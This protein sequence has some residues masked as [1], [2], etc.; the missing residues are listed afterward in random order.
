MKANK[1]VKALIC[2]VA[3]VVSVPLCAKP[4]AKSMQSQQA[5]EMQLSQLLSGLKTMQAN[6][7]Q[8]SYDIHG[9]ILQK[10]TGT[11]ALQR[12]GKFRW[13]IKTPHKQMYIADGTYLWTYDAALAQ[14][15]KQRLNPAKNNNPASLLSGSVASLQ[16]RFYVTETGNTKTGQWFQLKPKAKN[17][18]FRYIELHFQNNQLNEMKLSDNLGQLST[19][20]FSN[21]QI[22]TNLD[23]KL[24]QFAP[25]KA[26]DV[27]SS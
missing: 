5:A 13:N 9:K 23:Q 22:N 1:L 12:P 26:V 20:I 14:A 24:F 21:I 11:M 19:F 18:L 7:T 17:D 6:F 25:P 4:A 27:I 10:S 16:Q 8:N 15:T 2:C 3:V